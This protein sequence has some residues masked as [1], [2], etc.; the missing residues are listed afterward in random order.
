MIITCP[1]CSKQYQISDQMLGPHGRS[2]QCDSCQDDWFQLPELAPNRDMTPSPVEQGFADSPA[3]NSP[4]NQ[5]ITETQSQSQS[6]LGYNASENPFEKPI[7]DSSDTFDS[8]ANETSAADSQVQD[9]LAD[10]FFS[11][12]TPTPAAENSTITESLSELESL[13]DPFDF[14]SNSPSNNTGT[15]SNDASNFDWNE[16]SPPSSSLLDPLATESIAAKNTGDMIGSIESQF[17]TPKNAQS[18]SLQGESVTNIPPLSD[19]STKSN[20][21]SKTLK[22]LNPIN[23]IGN[24]RIVSAAEQKKEEIELDHMLK[25][26]A[27]EMKDLDN[28]AGEA[29]DALLSHHWERGGRVKSGKINSKSKITNKTKNSNLM[30]NAWAA[31][32]FLL[33]V[34]SSFLFLL[35]ERSLVVSWVPKT[36]RLYQMVGIEVPAENNGIDLQ[37]LSLNPIAQN[38]AKLKGNSNNFL[39]QGYIVNLSNSPRPVKPIQAN[40]INAQGKIIATWIIDAK[41]LR[42]LPGER[43]EFKYELSPLPTNS[44]TMSFNFV[45]S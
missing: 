14:G 19:R 45:N 22:N 21:A 20:S 9:F 44:A 34:F 10:D 16:S 8:G 29:D 5:S 26:L 18:F 3:S 12:T 36:I 35:F 11:A 4:S 39:V 42:I 15:N 7:S 25:D 24:I 2:V 38:G 13:H 23:W 17:D 30:I 31:G 33:V 43:I 32:L 40:A 1:S 37:S 28:L 41:V 27:N 6:P